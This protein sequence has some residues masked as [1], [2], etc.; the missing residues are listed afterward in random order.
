M[1]YII[2]GAPGS[3]KDSF[4]QKVIQITT[5][6]FGVILSTVDLVKEIAKDLGWDGKKTQ[7]DRKFLSDLKDILTEW[8]DIPIKDIEGRIDGFL[9]HIRHA[10]LDEK[11]TAIFVV[12]RE[13][14]EIEK[15]CKRL[16]AK[17][18][19]VRREEAENS[20]KSNHAD[21]E[22]LNYNYDIEIDNNGTLLDLA[23]KAIEFVER[24]ELHVN[25]WDS[26]EIDLFGNLRY[27]NNRNK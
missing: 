8:D 1:I 10:G 15:M 27:N 7:K 20:E 21:R 6:D 12:C 16:N 9:Y 24:E 25:H 19:I 14:E 22:V 11:E 23:Y 26:L 5:P 4:C 17:S 2:N 3:G 18:L 13:P